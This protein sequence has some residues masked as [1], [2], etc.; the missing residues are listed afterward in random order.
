MNRLRGE[1]FNDTHT[2]DTQDSVG[3]SPW[4]SSTKCCQ[5]RTEELSRKSKTWKTYISYS[6]ERPSNAEKTK[7][8][9]N[10][11]K[12]RWAPSCDIISS[13]RHVTIRHETHQ[14]NMLGADTSEKWLQ[15]S[16]SVV[17]AGTRKRGNGWKVVSKTHGKHL[18]K[19]RR[20]KHILSAGEP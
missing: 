5:Q 19:E 4:A 2:C 9:K 8:N 3:S 11:M 10:S 18:D 17:V 15:I 14:M 16:V 12:T 1:I 13:W 20:T 7:W 6:K